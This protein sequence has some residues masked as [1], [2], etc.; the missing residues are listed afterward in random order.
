MDN[1]LRNNAFGHDAFVCTFAGRIYM[2][3]DF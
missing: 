3:L 2:R 1:T